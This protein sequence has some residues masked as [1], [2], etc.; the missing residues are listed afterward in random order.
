MFLPLY[1]L[2]NLPVFNVFF[3][4]SVPGKCYCPHFTDEKWKHRKVRQLTE[5]GTV[6][7]AMEKKIIPLVQ[8]HKQVAV[9]SAIFL[10]YDP[11]LLCPKLESMHNLTD[12]LSLT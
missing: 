1:Y 7:F 12:H 10:L 8:N 4:H 11:D 5:D 9:P 6:K 2:G 3:S